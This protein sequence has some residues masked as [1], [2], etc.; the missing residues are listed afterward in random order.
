MR[1]EIPPF[2]QS[3]RIEG[4]TIL[5]L[6]HSL[7]DQEPSL[8]AIAGSIAIVIP[9]KAGIQRLPSGAQRRIFCICSPS[10]WR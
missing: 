4:M 9:A 1:V 3:V 6:R 8:L 7:D 2:I 10:G 5:F